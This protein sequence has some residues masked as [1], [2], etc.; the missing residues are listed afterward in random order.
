MPGAADLEGQVRSGVFGGDTFALEG[1]AAGAR[2]VRREPHS[3]KISVTGL[4]AV[5]L[6]GG[7]R[8]GGKNRSLPPSPR[9][10]LQGNG[11]RP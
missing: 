8:G 3:A 1:S 9:N 10:M 11:A 7:H 5:A 2:L 6:A 4:L